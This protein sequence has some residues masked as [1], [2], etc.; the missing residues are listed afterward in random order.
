ME[1]GHHCLVGFSHS[2]PLF[3]PHLA[4][5]RLPCLLPP[6]PPSPP[7]FL[8][9]W[10]NSTYLDNGGNKNDGNNYVGTGD[11]FAPSDGRDD[12]PLPVVPLVTSVQPTVGDPAG[13]ELIHL[14][15]EYFGRKGAGKHTCCGVVAL[16]TIH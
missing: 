1:G 14:Y 11:T 15:G 13:G 16:P 6:P 10:H 7:L 8:Q 4:P 3:S 5:L 2:P 9:V 12:V